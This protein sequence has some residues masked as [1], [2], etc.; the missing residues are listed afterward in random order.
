MF[1]HLNAYNE[2]GKQDDIQQTLKSPLTLR[3][4]TT[5]YTDKLKGNSSIIK[6]CPY[7]LG[8]QLYT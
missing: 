6:H 3:H 8:G 4:W 1:T 5:I 7:G 2:Q